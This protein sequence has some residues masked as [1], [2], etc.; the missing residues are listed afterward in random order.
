VHQQ[1]RGWSAFA[2]HDESAGGSVNLF[3]RWYQTESAVFLIC[4][5]VTSLRAALAA[6]QSR[7]AAQ[8]RVQHPWIASSLRSSQ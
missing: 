7:G 1:R 3:G 5:V 8:T 4:H 2:D 6:K